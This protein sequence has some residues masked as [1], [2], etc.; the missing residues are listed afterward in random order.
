MRKTI[1]FLTLLLMMAWLT[2]C[3]LAHD[4]KEA[5]CEEPKT[6]K[7]CGETEGEAL[8]H[9]W[10][11]ATCNLAKTCEV[12]GKTEGDPLGHDWREATCQKLKTCAVCG[13]TEGDY[14]DHVWIAA[15]CLR[16]KHCEICGV[17]EGTTL[18]H[19]WVA[20]SYDSSRYC[21]VCG[22]VQ[23]DELT[24]AFEKRNYEF[25]LQKGTSWEYSTIAN[26]DDKAV[27]ATATITDYRKY[28]SDSAHA[29]LDGYEWREVTV[30][31]KSATGIKVMFGYTDT[32]AGLEEYPYSNYITYSNGTKLGVLADE[33]FRYE[34]QD[35]ETCISYGNLAVRVPEDYEDLVFYVCSADYAN[36]QRIDPNIKF[37]EMK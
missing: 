3:C 31:F 34:W 29:A 11:D 32:Y 9:V 10:L 22:V 8:G 15:S 30:E 17:T 16:P 4:W 6:C 21:S 23:G 27:S 37:M 5:N 20:A 36:T 25:T 12:C 33:E 1:S 24:P 14:A 35:D 19:T 28:K 26:A 18:N 7:I 13:A 2:G